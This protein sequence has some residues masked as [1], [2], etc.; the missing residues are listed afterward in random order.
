G[1]GPGLRLGAS[2]GAAHQAREI[3][4]T[5]EQALKGP[6]VALNLLELLLLFGKLKKGGSIASRHARHHGIIRGHSALSSK[7]FRRTPPP[8]RLQSGCTGLRPN[9]LGARARARAPR[10]A[11]AVFAS[12]RPPR[13]AMPHDFAADRARAATERGSRRVIASNARAWGAGFGNVKDRVQEK[14]M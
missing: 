8:R 14:S 2:D 10:I 7:N 6:N 9:T 13:H 11:W 5:L 1:G 3:G 12:N 4:A